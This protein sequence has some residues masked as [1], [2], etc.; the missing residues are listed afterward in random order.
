MIFYFTGTGNSLY[1]AKQ[2]DD[3]AI[4]IPQI[5]NSQT[6]EFSAET[7]GIVCPIYG[8][9]MPAMVKE[10]ICRAKLQT[11]YLYL[12]LTYGKRHANAVELA[13]RVF[14]EA[15]KRLDYCAT[16]LMVD[17]FL[18]VFDMNE[19]MEIDKQVEQQLAAIKSDIV[20]RMQKIEAVT[21][22]DRQAHQSYLALANNAAETVWA[23]F[24]I[25]D[26]CVGCGICTKVC[27]AGCIY[28]DKQRAVHTGINCQACFACIHACPKLAIRL[29]RGEKNPQA[30]YRNPN[31][32]LGEIV[33]ANDQTI[34][35]AESVQSPVSSASFVRSD[36]TT[37]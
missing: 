21:D 31:T 15:G 11:E 22:Q 9:E 7:I 23:D 8:H 1:A 14:S 17:N 19:E 35:R 33:S 32:T 36:K 6:L 37:D 24:T 34:C 5:L 27:P 26:D 4:S 16:L 25:T 10:F 2:L 3:R 12:I 18:P 13:E 30:R 20:S 29:P 28:L